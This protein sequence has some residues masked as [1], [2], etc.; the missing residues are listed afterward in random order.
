MSRSHDRPGGRTRPGGPPPPASQLSWGA[1]AGAGVVVGRM[2]IGGGG[3]TCRSGETTLGGKA[4]HRRDPSACFRRERRSERGWGLCPTAAGAPQVA[5]AGRRR[6]ARRALRCRV[7]R[8]PVIRDGAPLVS[9]TT[10]QLVLPETV[11]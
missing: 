6:R 2:G 11:L 8:R 5:Q 7:T 4:W 9:Q 1:L 3:V 10:R